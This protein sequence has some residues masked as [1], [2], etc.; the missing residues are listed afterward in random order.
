MK[1]NPAHALDA[2]L[3]ISF[4]RASLA[5]ASDARRSAVSAMRLKVFPVFVSMAAALSCLNVAVAASIPDTRITPADPAAA[6]RELVTR[7]LSQRPSESLTNQ[8]LLCVHRTKRDG[9]QVPLRITVQAGESS[10]SITYSTRGTNQDHAAAFTVQHTVK[11]PD[12]YRVMLFSRSPGVTNE[13][14]MLSG[15]H[16]YLPFADSDFGLADLGMEFLHWPTQRLLKKGISHSRSCNQLESVA[17]PGQ[18]KTYARV[19]SWF[20]IETGGLL[21]AKAYDASGKVV[22]EFSPTALKKLGDRYEVQEVEMRNLRTG[23][24]SVL[25]FQ[26]DGK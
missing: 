15:L 2:G 26:V 13:F 10:W 12:E 19:L 25:S 24:R 1:A 14:E 22:K 6:G 23:S 4:N 21:A 5:R 17:P 18:T 16:A 20:D 3:R 8:G 11:G 9:F 7:L